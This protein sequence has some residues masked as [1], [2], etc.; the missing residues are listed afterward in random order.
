VVSLAL[1]LNL[2]YRR[3]DPAIYN[4]EMPSHFPYTKVFIDDL[5]NQSGVYDRFRY[6][7]TYIKIRQQQTNGFYAV[8]N[9][10]DLRT[11]QAHASYSNPRGKTTLRDVGQPLW[12]NLTDSML[13]DYVAD[14]RNAT[15]ATWESAINNS[16]VQKATDL[17][18]NIFSV[19]TGVDPAEK[20][21]ETIGA[22]QGKNLYRAIPKLRA[23]TKVPEATLD[24]LIDWAK[25]M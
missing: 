9:G 21:F 15:R 22:F 25:T 11:A 10:L 24:V 8:E 12:A 3:H 1:V 7:A 6:W 19:Y 4:P 5:V 23:A 16:V 14:A 17:P 20:V 13:K 18:E 2:G